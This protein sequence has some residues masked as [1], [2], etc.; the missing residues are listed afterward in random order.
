MPS[1]WDITSSCSSS[2]TRR[3]TPRYTQGALGSSWTIISLLGDENPIS[4]LRNLL[5]PQPQ[6]EFGFRSFQL[7]TTKTNSC[8]RFP[9]PLAKPLKIDW[10]TVMATRGKFAR[11][12]VEMDLT[13]PLKPKFMLENKCYNIEPI[14]TRKV[15]DIAGPTTKPNKFKYLEEEQ[16]GQ[17]DNPRGRKTNRAGIE[18]AHTDPL[19]QLDPSQPKDAKGNGK[20]EQGQIKAHQQC[21]QIRTPPLIPTTGASSSTIAEDSSAKAPVCDN[22]DI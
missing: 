5:K 15:Q 20:A 2:L 3:T 4:S 8:L 16:A 10:T 14:Q 1:I 17:E 19:T 11:I 6:Y 13:K 9:K 22:G 18:K 7:N 21:N 12:C